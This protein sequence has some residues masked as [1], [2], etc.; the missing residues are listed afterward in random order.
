MSSAIVCGATGILG[1]EIVYR[2]ASNPTKWKTI[3]AL[4]R[5]KKDDYPSNVV[6]NHIDLLHSAED[7]AKDLASVSGEY[8]FFAAYMQKDSEEENWKVNGD[9][10]ANFLR[11]LTLTG[12]AKSIKRI[13]LVT[14]CKQYGVHLG[15]AK[16]PMMESDPWLTDQNIYPP[17][18]YYRQQDI[19][20]DFCKANPHIGW[21]V[22][23]PNDVIGFANGNFMNLAS[24]LGIYA[25]VCKEQG[26]KLAFPGNE[27]F[28]SGF[29]CYTSSKLHAEFCEWV[30]C[31]DKTRNEAFN[32][33]NGDVQTWED[34]WPR[35]ARRFGMEV[36]QGQFQQEVGE[37]AGKVEMNEV[38]PIKAW[39][40]ELG[41]EG[42]VKRNMLSQRVSLVKW[43]EQEDVE[44]AWERLVEREGLQKDGLEKGTWAFVDFELGRDF[45]LVI[46]MSKAREFGWTGYQDTWKAFSDVF[47]ELEAAKVLPK[48]H[49]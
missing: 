38:P 12:A 16:N 37:L 9:M 5:S 8:V 27:G 14:G 39:E 32:L 7:M 31:E 17:N 41:L 30:V 20:H 23:Y 35:L 33:V 44:K 46:G 43:A 29:D 40:K 45:D 48:S 13:L 24:G 36:D 4:S 2:L 18:F 21:N 25:A 34:M 3:H 49:K 47:G 15:R 19:L 10:L 1:R 11:A 6:H 28:Y 42:R 22:T 26:R